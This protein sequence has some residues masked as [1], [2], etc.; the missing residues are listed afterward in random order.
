M[1]DKAEV[2][3]K[4]MAASVAETKEVPGKAFD[5]AKM[6]R[7]EN[8]WIVV[9]SFTGEKELE[10]GDIKVTIDKPFKVDRRTSNKIALYL[11]SR[12]RRFRM[13]VLPENWKAWK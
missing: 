13:T 6:R 9:Q 5:V 12:G 10:I 1:Q 7:Q 4:A 3:N 2:E 8:E 11:S